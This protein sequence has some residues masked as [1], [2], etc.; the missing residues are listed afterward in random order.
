[1]QHTGVKEELVISVPISEN[2]SYTLTLE[3]EQ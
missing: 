1:M 3:D 2:K